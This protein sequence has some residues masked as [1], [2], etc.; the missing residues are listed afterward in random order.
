MTFTNI[1]KYMQE[2]D[3]NGEWLSAGEDEA[4]YI[5]RTLL[6]WHEGESVTPRVIGYMQHLQ[7]LAER[8]NHSAR[9]EYQDMESGERLTITLTDKPTKTIEQQALDF[10]HGTS[11]D[12]INRSYNDI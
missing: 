8:P 3:R 12:I 7:K 5:L 9:F 6:E 4:P 2:N 11:L 10:M 1:L